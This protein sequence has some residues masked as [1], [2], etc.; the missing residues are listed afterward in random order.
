MKILSVNG[1]KKDEYTLRPVGSTPQRLIAMREHKEYAGAMLGPPTSI[2]AER[3]GFVS[4]SSVQE[5]IGAYQAT[6]YFT[7]RQWAKEHATSLVAFLAAI[8]EAQRWF[9]AQLTNQ[10]L[11]H[12]ISQQ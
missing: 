2:V 9:M 1:L 12:L 11:I 8:I 7:Q 6:G 4:L 3:E 5:S 10:Q